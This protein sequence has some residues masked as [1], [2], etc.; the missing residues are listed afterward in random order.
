[1]CVCSP[2]CC[3]TKPAA[4]WELGVE[5]DAGMKVVLGRVLSLSDALYFQ[6]SA[7]KTEN[8][9]WTSHQ[10]GPLGP[11]FFFILLRTALKHRPKGPSTANHQ[12]P[13]TSNRHQLP[14]TNCQRRPNANHQLPT[15]ANCHQPPIPNHQ[16][17]PTTINHHQ[18]PSTAS[19]Q[20]PV[21]NRQSPTANCQHMVC[22][23]AFLGNLGIGTHLLFF[24]LC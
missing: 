6:V 12:P 14:T 4:R 7:A 13:P 1:M 10:G 19:H 9:K 3:A 5:D 17:P 18:P 24:L 11:R 2:P 8:Q 23:W 20:P 16:L 22:P 21:A 15:T